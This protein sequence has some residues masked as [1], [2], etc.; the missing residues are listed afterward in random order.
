MF[1]QSFADNGFVYEGD[2]HIRR[3]I[4]DFERLDND[5]R[6]LPSRERRC[7]TATDNRTRTNPARLTSFQTLTPATAQHLAVR[8]SLKRAH[9]YL[10][11][12]EVIEFD[13][14]KLAE[15]CAGRQ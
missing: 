10:L 2:K 11:D 9:S 14:R 3:P 6:I 1:P 15:Q 7:S 4:G 12:F 5:L 13:N 8:S